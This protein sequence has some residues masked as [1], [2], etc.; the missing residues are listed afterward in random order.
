M[1]AVT[2][3]QRRVLDFIKGFIETNRYSPSFDEIADGLGLKSLATVSKHIG[4]LK[5]KGLLKDSRNRSRSLEIVA[6]GT[7]DSRFVLNAAGTHLRDNVENCWW[8]REK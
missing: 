5:E 3:S 1:A 7:L 4:H 8:V 6:P 2:K